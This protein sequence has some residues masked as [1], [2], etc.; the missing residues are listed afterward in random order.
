MP[1]A[2]FTSEQNKLFELTRDLARNDF[3]L[4]VDK[5]KVSRSDLENYLRDK[6]NNDILKG[7]T[8]YQAYRR[9]NIVLFEIIE[10][11]INVTIDEDVFNSA[12]VENFV[13]VKNR[14]LGD[15]TAFYHEG[16]MLSVS[17]FAGNHWDT[18][19][20][21]IDLGEEFTLPK[22]W[23]FIHVYD[24]LERF[25]VG[26]VTLERLVDKVYKAINRFFS[27][28]MYA[29][30]ANIANALPSA[31][32]ATG[33]TEAAVGD[34]IDLV[35]AAGGYANVNIAGTPG[36]LRKLAGYIPT[37]LI[38]DSQKEAKANNGDIG[39][40]EG[41]KLM[42]IPQVLIPGTYTKRLADNKLFILGG[43][44]KPIKF[45]IFGDTRTDMD[46]TGKK[47][48]DMTLDFQV[49]TKFGMGL[50]IPAYSG[51]FTLQ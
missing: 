29:Q 9:N 19:R 25:L 2:N 41:H 39:V 26:A 35:Q 8:L 15:T 28:R 34:L 18:N 32:S 37:N 47:Y 30:F 45:E 27:E 49:Q 1:I 24:E 17:T 50:V 6:I 31:F 40:W 20:Q 36:A 46:T 23:C 42:V 10:E 21:A 3:A 38:A 33:N 14:R 4:H 12:F 16:G 48:N 22:E 51:V 13:E 44:T 43:D 5:E 7:A 11:I